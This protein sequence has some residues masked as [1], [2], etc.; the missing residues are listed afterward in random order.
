[1]NRRGNCRDNS[2]VERFFRSLKNEWMSA[3]GYPQT[4]RKIDSGK[5]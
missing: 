5:L 2:P 4:N 1:M 3:V